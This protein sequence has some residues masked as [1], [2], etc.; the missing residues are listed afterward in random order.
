M[1]SPALNTPVASN[2]ATPLLRR[3]RRWR[4][5]LFGIATLAVVYVGV[6]VYLWVV[7][8][9]LMFKT[10]PLSS[11]QA[12]EVR[13]AFPQARSVRLSAV[14]GTRLHAWYLAAATPA[15]P[16]RLLLYFGANNEH[17]H[18]M[19]ARHPALE[20]W[21]LLLVDYR[22]YGLSGGQ[23]SQA[24]LEKDAVQWLRLAREGGDGVV[25]PDRLVVMGV[26]VGS[27]IAT[28]LAAA[29]PVDGVVVVV[30]FDSGL[31]ITQSMMPIY[32]M[33]W[34]VR[35]RWETIADAPNVRAPTLFFVAK[36]DNFV[37]PERSRR[38]YEAWGSRPRQWVELANANHYTVAADP[39]YWQRL[40]EFL[41]GL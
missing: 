23:P 40:G 27:Y 22:G 30:P 28:H 2:G 24:A 4:H 19:L 14:D 25:K 7:Q 13:A 10:R 12:A 6:F 31:E 39:L 41:N 21:D 5:L 1:S 34:I 29:H 11:E 33:G 20:G 18:W 38:L 35:H 16:R 37:A 3:A 8:E 26:S 9:R 32:P 36:S 17:V 15:S